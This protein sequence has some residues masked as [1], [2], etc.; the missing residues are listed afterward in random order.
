MNDTAFEGSTLVK[1]LGEAMIAALHE[2][3]AT[4]PTISHAE[5]AATLAYVIDAASNTMTD[6]DRVKEIITQLI[7]AQ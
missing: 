2:H 1:V 7:A 3:A 6:P 5:M 4:T